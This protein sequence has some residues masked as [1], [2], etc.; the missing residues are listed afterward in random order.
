[1]VS[2]FGYLDLNAYYHTLAIWDFDDEDI[3]RI[4]A[5]YPLMRWAAWAV[6]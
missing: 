2:S 3:Y 6:L 5:Q 4:T 1:M